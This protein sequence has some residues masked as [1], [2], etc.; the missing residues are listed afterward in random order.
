MTRKK[1]GWVEDPVVEEVRAV[2]ADLWREG[3]GTVA[4]L[5]RAIEE[6]KHAPRRTK[7]PKGAKRTSNPR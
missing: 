7:S 5:I 1:D 2:R 4:G 3:G 6:R